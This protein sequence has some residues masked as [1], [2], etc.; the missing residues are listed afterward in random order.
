MNPATEKQTEYIKDLMF[1]LSEDDSDINYNELSFSEAKNIIEQL[2]F[3]KE[4]LID[5]EQ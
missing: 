3:K 1:K 5:D 2:L 4:G